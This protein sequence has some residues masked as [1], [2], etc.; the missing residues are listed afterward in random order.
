MTYFMYKM[1]NEE[2]KARE[3]YSKD[4]STKLIN[5]PGDIQEGTSQTGGWCLFEYAAPPTSTFKYCDSW[6]SAC[7]RNSWLAP[8]EFG[9]I[10]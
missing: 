8:Y 1:A 9:G 4:Y 3:D 7:P 10:F 2:I 5:S 6:H